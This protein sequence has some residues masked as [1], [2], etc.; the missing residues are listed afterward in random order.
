MYVQSIRKKIYEIVNDHSQDDGIYFAAVTIF[1][2]LL[3]SVVHYY[4]FKSF[5]LTLRSIVSRFMSLGK[6]EFR[7]SSIRIAWSTVSKTFEKFR[8]VVIVLWYG[9]SWLTSF[10][11]W[12]VTWLK[13]VVLLCIFLQPCYC[14]AYLLLLLSKQVSLFLLWQQ[15]Y[16]LNTTWNSNRN[17]SP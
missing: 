5:R 2:L 14:F 6:F 3:T 17:Y 1:K 15:K 16:L 12:L 11:M 9:L 10:M 8:V 13:A 4:L 7:M